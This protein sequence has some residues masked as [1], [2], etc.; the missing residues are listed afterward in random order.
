MAT[1]RHDPS[2]RFD[3]LEP[4]SGASKSGER[5]HGGGSDGDGEGTFLSVVAPAK[6]ESGNLP[7][8][9]AETAS[10]FRPLVGA[11]GAELGHRL[12]GF[13]IVIVDDGSTD[14]TP[15]LLRRLSR[16][17]PEL[18]PIRLER[19]SG[20]SAA[21]AH[22]FQAARGDWIATL[23][24]DLQNPP[25]ELVKLWQALPGHDAALGW[26]VKR[27]DVWSKRIVSRWANR[28]RNALLRQ[29]IKDTGCAARIFRRDIALRL[30][31]FHGVHRFFGPLLI[32]EG[33]DIVQLPIQHRPRS[34]GQSHYSF[35]N[36]SFKVI[37]DLLGVAWLMR[38]PL[39][40]S[41]PIHSLIDEPTASTLTTPHGSTAY[42]YASASASSLPK[43]GADHDD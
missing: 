4:A 15:Q 11:A 9:I 18:R 24:A 43:R 7:Q 40:A 25:A 41:S 31:L 36:R 32:R 37:V 33:C 21:L 2:H 13:E 16:D 29:S 34:H 19:N 38:R 12:R 17:Y 20:Q 8:L 14:E 1:I 27:E 23:D 30:P 22:G 39:A 5:S 26:R 10:A 6:N 28:V 35:R 3:S 42:S